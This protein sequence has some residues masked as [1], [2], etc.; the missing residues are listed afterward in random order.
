VLTLTSKLIG[1]CSSPNITDHG[2][3]HL[4]L[5]LQTSFDLA[6]DTAQ[7]LLT[8]NDAGVLV[9]A[10]ALHDFGMYL[11]RDGFESLISKGSAW[12][13]IPEFDDKPWDEL[14]TEFPL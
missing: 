8:A 7:G 14:W 6:T 3:S 12:P 11:T 9:V 13:G 10:V 2:I 1:W 5:T 4:E